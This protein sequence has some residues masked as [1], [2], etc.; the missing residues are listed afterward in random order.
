[1]KKGNG[2]IKVLM[3]EDN[4]G[5]ARLIHEMLS[6]CREASFDIRQAGSLK[7]GFECLSRNSVEV[8]L[9]DLIL[10]DSDGLDT[11]KKVQS[12]YPDVPILLLTGT[13]DKMLGSQAISGGAQDYLVK[14]H[15]DCHILS[16]SIRYAIERYKSKKEIE[17]N[18]DTQRA[19]NSLIHLSLKDI[20]LEVILN[21]AL[22]CIL[23]P[24]SLAFDSTGSIFLVEDGTENLVMKAYKGNGTGV[25]DSCK[26]I[27]F[28]RCLCGKAALTGKI[29]FAKDIASEN[30]G[31]E[32]PLPQGH[33]CVPV[34]FGKKVLGVMDIKVK[35]GHNDHRREKEFL[36]SVSETLAGIII[37]KDTEERERKQIKWLDALRKIDMAISSTLDLRVTL[38]VLLEEAVRQLGMDAADILL[39]NPHTNLLEWTAGNGFYSRALRCTKLKIGEGYAGDAV[40]RR[41]I[42]SIADLSEA[43]NGFKRSPLLTQE[44]FVSYFAVPLIAKG[45]VKGVLEI[46]H[47]SRF[48]PNPEWLGFLDALSSQAAIAI[49]N[50][51]LFEDLQRSNLELSLAYDD[52]I[53]GWAKA[54]DLR[55]KET[56]GHSRRVTEMTVRVA[57]VMGISDAGLVHV[58]RG[59]LLHDMGKMGIPDN[60]LLK[61]GPLTDNEWVIMKKHPVYAYEML[62]PIE[63]LRPAIEIPYCHHEKWDGTGYPRGLK[64]KEIPLPA[65]IFALVDVWDALRSD[66]PYRLAWTKEKVIK[67]VKS[68]AG[69]HFDP[70]V[71]KAFMEN[72]IGD[73]Y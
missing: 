64:G 12:R 28:G 37:R 70:E 65:R 4:P 32:K 20:S 61:P 29:Q 39:L 38:N 52:T 22:D 15:I 58:R 13:N 43:G 44:N 31:R 36:A 51:S 68:L 9:L 59:A 3:I 6:E 2:S 69:T 8:V 30:G 63:Y 27:P 73:M 72:G 60:I 48:E 25:S 57:Q 71:V 24:S 47:R 10:P 35:N 45:Q 17:R 62:S 49:D 23:S 66:R 50:A 53:E 40:L 16:R 67:H 19:I 14:G 54:L 46:F 56:E 7:E 21:K 18:Y 41:K 42:V 55:D 1:M 26:K 5:D 33:Y 34:M 11:F